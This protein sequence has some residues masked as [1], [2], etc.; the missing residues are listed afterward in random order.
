MIQCNGTNQISQ[1]LSFIKKTNN[2]LHRVNFYISKNIY[3]IKAKDWKYKDCH[4]TI[5]NSYSDK[6]SSHYCNG[7][8][9]T[10]INIS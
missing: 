7:K 6:T 1:L 5:F 4:C 3:F 10:T 2:Q 8:P 9:C